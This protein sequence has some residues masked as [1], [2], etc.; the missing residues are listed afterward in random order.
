MSSNWQCLLVQK[1]KNCQFLNL[2]FIIRGGSSHC[3]ID[4]SALPF[5]YGNTR[6]GRLSL[7]Q[8]LDWLLMIVRSWKFLFFQRGS[9]VH[10]V[11]NHWF[12]YFVDIYFDLFLKLNNNEDYFWLFVNKSNQINNFYLN[13]MKP[14]ELSFETIYLENKVHFNHQYNFCHHLK[15]WYW[16]Q[17]H[18]SFSSS[19]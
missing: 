1:S 14:Y 10:I 9:S 3:R 2:Q 5:H 7:N 17:Y 6:S 15:N 19:R 11:N 12:S 4:W 18:S 13:L 8:L 16:N